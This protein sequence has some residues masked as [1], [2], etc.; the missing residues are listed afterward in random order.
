[1]HDE[2]VKLSGEA[3]RP[4]WNANDRAISMTSALGRLREMVPKVH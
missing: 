4:Y 3:G 2:R 1:M